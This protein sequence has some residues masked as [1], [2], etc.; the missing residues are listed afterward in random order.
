LNHRAPF[1]VQELCDLLQIPAPE[2][3]GGRTL[4]GI[5]PLESAGENDLSFVLKAKFVE[6]AVSSRAA[7]L[8]AP[9]GL[10]LSHPLV[11]RVPEVMP[12]VIRLLEALFPTPVRSAFVHPSAVVDPTA[13]IG[14]NVHIGPGVV[15]EAGAAI[16]D[17]A[18]IEAQCF[19]GP[20][21]IVG[22]A[23]WLAPRVT[24]LE[25]TVLGQRVRIH[26][27]AVLGADGF[28]YEPTRQGVKKVPQ[29]GGV[30]VDDDAE[31][32][33]N[34]TIDRAFLTDTHIG[35]RTKIDNLV[36]IGHNVIIGSDC[37]I[38]AQVGVAGSAKVGRGVMIGGQ[39][40]I[41]DHVTIG[42][43][44]QVAGHSAVQGDIAPGARVIGFPAIPIRTWTRFIN[45]YKNFDREWTK[46]LAAPGDDVD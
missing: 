42:D 10:E 9:A 43:R 32:G 13:R 15:V 14:A 23:C 30:R 19:V 25:K 38:V 34:T 5:A 40:G 6:L 27:G 17:G 39:T 41:K 18:R 1:T 16:G 37:V 33:A 28:R 7:C 46:R 4:A 26:P 2:G 21:V 22:E 24:L 11:L 45:F 35:A 20:G 3:Q 31:I 44:A 36:H 29:V 8:L 12:A